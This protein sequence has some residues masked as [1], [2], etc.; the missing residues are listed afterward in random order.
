MLRAVGHLAIPADKA[1]DEAKRRLLSERAQVAESALRTR[2]PSEDRLLPTALGNV[3]RS[4]EDRHGR[5]YGLDSVLVWPRLYPLLPPAYAQSIEDEVIQ[6]DVSARLVITWA[7][8]G[9]AGAG[10][11]LHDIAGTRTHPGWI[12]LVAGFCVLS[13]MSYRAA[14]ESALAHGQD[15]EVALDLYRGLVLD[16]TRMPR[17]KRLSHERQINHQLC[18]LLETYD[19]NRELEIRYRP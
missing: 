10:I 12:L 1:R 19:E 6:L 13:R 9:G 8:A 15:V 4:A 17:P 11:L 3:L 18:A 16:I 7:L 5:R 2:F 14:I